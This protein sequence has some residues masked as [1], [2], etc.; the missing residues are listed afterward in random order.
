MIKSSS[1][2]ASRNTDL[3]E[4]IDLLKSSYKE[5]AQVFS[6]LNFL[7]KISLNDYL[8]KK[9]FRNICEKL[10]NKDIQTI[11]IIELG[12]GDG[13][14]LREIHQ[15]F[16]SHGINSICIGYDFNPHLIQLAKDQTH[17]DSIQFIESDILSPN[18][19]LPHCDFS[20]GIE[21]FG[22]VGNRCWKCVPGV[23]YEREGSI[24]G[25]A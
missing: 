24:R 20:G 1:K 17:N 15:I 10:K 18:F 14:Y 7:N 19:E 4:Q 8:I 12:C 5:D 9:G 3:I 25:G 6:Q 11:S 16:D 13:K 23:V 21:R 22:I 2:K